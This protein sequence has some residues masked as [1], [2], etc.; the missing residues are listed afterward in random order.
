MII[1]L[2]FTEKYYS[3]FSTKLTKRIKLYDSTNKLIS[4]KATSPRTD[5][6]KSN[7]KRKHINMTISMN[8]QTKTPTDISDSI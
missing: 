2:K 5:I 7:V 8:S 4:Q 6:N 3:Y 1:H